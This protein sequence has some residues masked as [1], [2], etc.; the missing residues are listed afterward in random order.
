MTEFED[1]LWKLQHPEAWWAEP[2]DECAT[3]SH[4]DG[5]G[6]LQIFTYQKEIEVERSDLDML[7][8][9]EIADGVAMTDCRLGEFN[10][11]TGELDDDSQYWKLWF[12]SNGSTAL[13]IT[14]TCDID[15]KDAEAGKIQQILYSLRAM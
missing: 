2:S 4:P 1:Q 9:Q 11:F 13:S 6:A 10:G 15:D 3:F 5:I 12:V 14:Y 8:E 7:A